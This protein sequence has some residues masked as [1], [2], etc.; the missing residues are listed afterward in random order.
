MNEKQPGETRQ[1]APGKK[2]SKRRRLIKRAIL[3]ALLAV[4]ISAGVVIYLVKSEPAYWKQHELPNVCP[5]DY[6]ELDERARTALRRM[7]RKRRLVIA[8]WNQSSLSFD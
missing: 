1:P 7:R 4:V 2:P 6:W 5:N 8:F 3:L